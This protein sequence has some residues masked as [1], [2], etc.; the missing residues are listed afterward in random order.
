MEKSGDVRR[1]QWQHFLSDMTL[2]VFQRWPGKARRQ[3]AL[4]LTITLWLW[5]TVLF[6]NFAEAVAEGEAGTSGILEDRQ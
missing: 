5:F 1:L 6:A 2:L 4:S 3:P